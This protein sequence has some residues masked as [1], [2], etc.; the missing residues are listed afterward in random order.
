[1]SERCDLEAIKARADAADARP[2]GIPQAREM[3]ALLLDVHDLVAEVAALREVAKE[4]AEVGGGPEGW[5]V[6]SPPCGSC[7]WCRLKLALAKV[8][9]AP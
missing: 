6:V 4:A 2:R 8:P 7:A 3:G 9:A 1:M 5:C